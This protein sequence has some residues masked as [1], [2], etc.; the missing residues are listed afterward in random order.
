[1]K[2]DYKKF[3]IITCPVCGM[4]YLPAE[5]F[6]PRAF[7]GRPHSIDKLSN[8]KID[9]YC[10]KSMDTR[11]NYI[12][13]KCGTALKVSAKFYFR[14]EVDEKRNFNKDFVTKVFDQIHLKED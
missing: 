13:D 5:I 1:M 8:G 11:E 2:N 12:C 6:V 9:S 3:D 4:E 7:F 10:G 14:A